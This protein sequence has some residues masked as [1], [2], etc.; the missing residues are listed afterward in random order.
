M[1][2]QDNRTRVVLLR[3]GIML[4]PREGAL[5]KMLAPFRLFAGGPFGSGSAVHVMDPSR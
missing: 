2:V 4:D 1:A 3:T 5:P